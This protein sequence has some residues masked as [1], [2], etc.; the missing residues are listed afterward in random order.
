MSWFISIWIFELLT[1]SLSLQ[2]FRPTEIAVNSCG[3]ST[4]G[5][6]FDFCSLLLLG[7]WFRNWHVLNYILG[8]QI[9]GNQIFCLRLKRE[10]SQ[11]AGKK[12][13]TAEINGSLIWTCHQLD[14]SC[15]RSSD[16]PVCCTLSIRQ[17]QWTQMYCRKKG[18]NV[19]DPTITCV[20]PFNF[21]RLSSFALFLTLCSSTL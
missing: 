1:C 9:I 17:E 21:F 20:A 8:F 19:N 7:S 14:A 12:Y 13:T 16:V 5:F 3:A 10:E 15:N 2:N 18:A 4:S 11:G 6:A